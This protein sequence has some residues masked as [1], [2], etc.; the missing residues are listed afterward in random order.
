MGHAQKGAPLDGCCGVYTEGMSEDA[1]RELAMLYVEEIFAD[2][3]ADMQR[4]GVRAGK[5]RELARGTAQ[6]FA[7]DIENAR[8]NRAGI[9]RRNGPGTRLSIDE[10]FENQFRAW[11]AKTDPD[12]M[13]TSPGYFKTGTTSDALKSIGMKDETVYWRKGK[14]GQIMMDHPEM[15][16]NTLAKVP[17]ILE[18][19]VAVM[20]SLTVENSI[21]VFGNLNAANGAK[22]MAAVLLTPTPAGGM[23]AEFQLISG[24]YSRSE[25]SI[26]NMINNNSEFLYLDPQKSRTDSWLRSLGLQL[27]SHQSVYGPI[28]SIAYIDGGVNIN[29][30]KI[31]FTDLGTQNNPQ[32]PSDEDLDIQQKNDDYIAAV[33]R[34]D[35]ETAQRMVDEA[36]KRAGYDMELYHGSKKG[37]GF[38]VFKDWQYFT[39]NKAYAERYMERDNPDSLYH[40]YVKSERMFDTRRP[41]CR[42]IFEQMRAEYG[43]SELQ[44]NGLPDWTDGYDISDFIEENGLDFDGVVLDEGGDL[45]E[46]GPVSRGVSYIIRNSEQVKSAEPVAYDDNGDPVDLSERFRT[47]RSGEEAWKNRDIRFSP[48]EDAGDSWGEDWI[49]KETGET[50]SSTPL[51]SAQNDKTGDG[52]QIAGAAEGN[53]GRPM[54]APTRDRG[55]PMTAPTEGR[56]DSSTPL[57]S[58]LNDNGV[59]RR[60]ASEENPSTASRSSSP[61][62]RGGSAETGSG[63]KE[64]PALTVCR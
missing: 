28:G 62:C 63:R 23:T 36:A 29:G 19:P 59:W 26:R 43:L 7:G 33:N 3:Y 50:D 30:T 22:V 24:S 61:A 10:N 56:T 54:S 20:K 45:T 52:R 57:R 37:G 17:T 12:V 55:R 15:D 38:T 64:I 16:I 21:V 9:E 2:V 1:Q 5:A 51:R 13:A 44:E 41:E 6:R 27:P 35:T 47:D 48:S 53:G 31:Q 42:E 11:A 40:V 46:D 60:R 32:M 14:I 39:P 58:A 8:Q 34:G 49:G 4:G 25:V 18:R